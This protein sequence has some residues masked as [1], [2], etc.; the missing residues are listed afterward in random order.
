[1]NLLRMVF[2][3]LLA[4]TAS[5]QA[6]VDDEDKA[7]Q[8]LK[9][10]LLDK[11][12]AASLPE[13][14]ESAIQSL[15]GRETHEIDPLLEGILRA[16]PGN[17]RLHLGVAMAFDKIPHY[18]G[19]VE[20]KFV[21]GVTD[22]WKA[23][24][25]LNVE[26]RDRVRAIQV[27]LSV[28]ETAS[29]D[30][31]IEETGVIFL[32]LA[33][34]L[35]MGRV[36]G[37]VWRLH[38]LTDLKALPESGDPRG[39]TLQVNWDAGA[40]R[41]PTEELDFYSIPP[42][43]EA[44]KND[45]ERWRWA[46][47]EA[48]RIDPSLA[49]TVL[50]ERLELLERVFDPRAAG[51]KAWLLGSTDDPT[52]RVIQS[53]KEDET[54]VWSADGIRRIQLPAEHNP[55]EI[56]K[57]TKDHGALAQRF[58]DRGQ[59]AR[60]AECWKKLEG[61]E[62]DPGA[63]GLRQ[64]TGSL[65]QLVDPGTFKGKRKALAFRY[66]NARH[67]TFVARPVDLPALTEDLLTYLRSPAFEGQEPWNGEGDPLPV[68]GELE[69][70]LGEPAGTWERS[71][72]PA[73][74]HRDR[75]IWFEV[76][77]EKPGCY[78]VTATVDGGQVSGAPWWIPE[79]AIVQTELVDK[80][81]YF[82]AD[83]LTGEPVA[84]AV[85]SFSGF[86]PDPDEPGA[87]LKQASFEKSTDD[88]GQMTVGRQEQPLETMQWLIQARAPDGRRAALLGIPQIRPVHPPLETAYPDLFV[89]TDRPFYFPGQ[90][91]HL[92]GWYREAGYED[93][94]ESD[95]A[96]K[97]RTLSIH[98]YGGNLK[99]EEM[100]VTTDAFGGFEAS[101][102][103]SPVK[104]AVDWDS[105]WGISVDGTGTGA[106]FE[107]L[108]G[109]RPGLA[110]RVEMPA[111]VRFRGE[112]LKA[113]VR[114]ED[115][116]GWPVP[117]VRVRLTVVQSRE[118]QP[119]YPARPL[120]WLHGAGS[121]FQGD[122]VTG[123]P[124]WARWGTPALRPPYSKPIPSELLRDQEILLGDD[125]TFVLPV[126]T[127]ALD[128]PR[129]GSHIIV[130]AQV[131]DPSR[132]WRPGSA[133]VL[134]VP[135]PFRVAVWTTSG[136][137]TAG[138]TAEVQ[139]QA[140]I[141]DGTPVTGAGKLEVLTLREDPERSA[142]T[143]LHRIDI[144]LGPDG[145]AVARLPALGVGQ[146]RL[147]CQVTDGHGQTREG[148]T[149]ITVEGVGLDPAAVQYD[150]FHLV[151][152]HHGFQ[153]GKTAGIR[154]DRRREGGAMLLFLR[155]KNESDFSAEPQLV[156]FEGKSTRVSIPLGKELVPSML[157]DGLTVMDGEVHTVSKELAVLPENR[158]LHVDLN[159][160]GKPGV[161]VLKVTDEHGKPCSGTAVVSV[162]DE[163]L[164]DP[165][166]NEP[167][168][169]RKQ[170]LNETQN[171]ADLSQTVRTSLLQSFR[172]KGADAA[173]VSMVERGWFDQL[174]PPEGE[175]P[176]GPPGAG[177]PEFSGTEWRGDESSPSAMYFGSVEAGRRWSEDQQRKERKMSQSARGPS[178]RWR[179]M[180]DREEDQL[181]WSAGLTVPSSGT[182]EIPLTLPGRVATWKVQAWVMGQGTR[183]GQAVT[184]ITVR[185]DLTLRMRG[186][187]ISAGESE[188]V[189]EAFVESTL[190]H[191]VS[192]GVELSV[193]GKSLALAGGEASRTVEVPPGGEVRVEWRMKILEEG[194]ATL[195]VQA[196]AGDLN[197]RLETDFLVRSP[198]GKL[199]LGPPE[200]PPASESIALRADNGGWLKVCDQCL[201][202]TEGQPRYAL[203]VTGEGEEPPED[204]WFVPARLADGRVTLRH[205]T[206]GGMAAVCT[207]CIPGSS[208]PGMVLTADQS[209]KGGIPPS[210]ARFRM[211]PLGEG[212]WA[213]QAFDGNYASR[214]NSCAPSEFEDTVSTHAT[215]SGDP[216]S[217]WQVIEK[218]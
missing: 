171:G 115:E 217:Q 66:R 180:R 34:F 201:E 153:P 193:R 2:F 80:V 143:S 62:A 23:D 43:F 53:L 57:Q 38:D 103:I 4:G 178:A 162:Y 184:R 82:V 127:G 131:L 109:E 14:L 203:V 101:W 156:H 163:V 89:V 111:G 24:P 110:V 69:A 85:L 116:Q 135:E 194:P 173:P 147:A 172:L 63:D 21:R 183:V 177:T 212:K 144:T 58:Q 52:G 61:G 9:K 45:G 119:W 86:T 117:G 164:D 79:L 206:T 160:P 6:P 83:A 189:V 170:F 99:W 136:Q 129:D 186:P 142:E 36:G 192:V 208:Y 152:D 81:H 175:L 166:R 96:G 18:G 200:D 191:P 33:H 132:T 121:S 211:V 134:V 169:I 112:A 97:E 146:Y 67:V 185:K 133:S 179:S 13:D 51:E 41:G 140:A 106:G 91:V 94:A 73:P 72:D 100:T 7:Y 141:A 126:D 26:E 27:L 216:S 93:S 11:E 84:R 12:E 149:V 165:E 37:A 202:G 74:D 76:P 113:R 196:T 19:M 122:E 209:A 176:A 1:M 218:K 22:E 16:H 60:A 31:S 49:D 167:P 195:T 3:A 130:A 125:G 124:G 197:D 182:V 157:I 199:T 150:A 210:E 10:R 39:F 92:A 25:L 139:V 68:K 128:L 55:L 123:W 30:P 98:Q 87:K 205:M 42:S 40:W 64:V 161:V 78:W 137:V 32:W 50:T 75:V 145:R 181:H 174:V 104:G 151:P 159:T 8:V 118:E 59:Y 108:S 198:G 47:Q 190:D 54:L 158:L 204:A 5:G 107:I 188:G 65:G 148:G 15:S 29:R 114:A 35:G 207:G 95:L 154:F 120:D 155:S 70:F 138:E 56:L 48:A 215:D 105:S 102:Q 168:D 77:L 46:L 44:A 214:C 28:R 88:T 20:G 71:L 17:W 187:R 213:L 90:V